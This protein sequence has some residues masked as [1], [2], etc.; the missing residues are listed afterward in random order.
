MLRENFKESTRG[1]MESDWVEVS[2]RCLVHL[3]MLQEVCGDIIHTGV[4]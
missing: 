4:S 1:K 2:Y 3:E